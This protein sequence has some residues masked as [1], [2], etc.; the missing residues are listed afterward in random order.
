M[1]LLNLFVV[2]LSDAAYRNKSLFEEYTNP[3]FNIS[4]NTVFLFYLTTL[5]ATFGIIETLV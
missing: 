4:K 1:V 3:S 2:A 5:W